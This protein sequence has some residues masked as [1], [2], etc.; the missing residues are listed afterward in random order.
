MSDGKGELDQFSKKND[1]T[2]L[3]IGIPR[4]VPQ[5]RWMFAIIFVFRFLFFV[6]FFCFSVLFSVY[7]Q[8]YAESC[9]HFG[10]VRL[11]SLTAEKEAPQGRS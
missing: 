7:V 6:F 1:V 3:P 11:P 8:I 4:R 9:V 10:G 5:K 2:H